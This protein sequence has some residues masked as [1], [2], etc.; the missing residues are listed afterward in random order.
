M[1][2]FLTAAASMI[3]GNVIVDSV[4]RIVIAYGI[5]RLIN[6]N[7]AKDNTPGARFRDE[8]VRLQIAP[9]TTNHIPILFGSAFYGG[10]ITDAQLTNANKTMWYCITL[11]DVFGLK[12]DD[13]AITTR[14]TNVYWNNQRVVFKADG[15]TIDYVV[16]DDGVVDASARDLVKIYLYR[17]GSATPTVITDPETNNPVYGS[18]SGV[19]ARTL[20]PGWTNDH[21]MSNLTFALVKLDYNRDKGITGLPD[22]KFNV[23]NDNYLPGNAIYSYLLNNRVGCDLPTS[24]IDITNLNAL[25]DYADDEISYLDADGT[26]KT[27]GDR[28]QINGL[29]DTSN[30]VL[31]NLEKLCLSSGCYL[32]YDI[33]AGKWGVVINRDAE[34]SLDFDDSNIISGITVTGTALDGIYNGV[35]IEFPHRELRDQSDFI[36]ID[37]PSEYRNANEPDNTLKTKFE[38]LNEPLQARSL[39]YLELYQNRMDQ[40]VTFTTDYS[41][42]NTEAGDII[43]VTNSVYDWDHKEFRVIRVKEVESDEGGIAVEITAQEYDATMYQAGGQPRRPGVPSEPIGIPTL[44]AIGTPSAPTIFQTNNQNAQPNI[45]LRS[46]VPGSTQ[47]GTSVIVDRMEFWYAEGTQAQNIPT[48][49]YKLLEVSVN[50]NGNP[51]TTG[52]NQDSQPIITLDAGNYLFRVRA[53]NATGYSDYSAATALAW[54][55]KQRTDE[56]DENTN[57]TPDTPSLSDLL[58]PLAMGAIAY[59]AYQALKPEILAALSNTDLGKLLGITNPAEIAD[60]K[61]KMEQQAA[62]FRII[63]AGNASLSAIGDSTVTFIAGEGIEITAVDVGHEITISATGALGGYSFTNIAVSGQP[64]VVAD[65]VGDTVTLVAGTGISIIT[66][67]N[68]DT[69]TISTSDGGGGGGEDISAQE[70]GSY[71][72]QGSVFPTVY[73]TNAINSKNAIFTHANLI[74]STTSANGVFKN[75]VKSTSI[76]KPSAGYTTGGN[77]P[78]EYF[79]YATAPY[80][81]NLSLVDQAWSDWQKWLPDTYETFQQQN[82]STNPL[83]TTALP[84][85]TVDGEYNCGGLTLR[86]PNVASLESYNWFMADTPK[87]STFQRRVI[88]QKVKPQPGKL[89]IFGISIVDLGASVPY[90]TNTIFAEASTDTVKGNASGTPIYP[91]N[92]AY[93]NSKYVVSSGEDQLYYATTFGSWNKVINVTFEDPSVPAQGLPSSPDKNKIILAPYSAHHQKFIGLCN[94]VVRNR[95]EVVSS[96][97][98][99]NWTEHN[100]IVSAQP[101]RIQVNPQ[102]HYL[103]DNALAW[104]S[105]GSTADK[106]IPMYS[107]NGLDWVQTHSNI[108]NDIN[109]NTRWCPTNN[110]WISGRKYFDAVN[111]SSISTV[112]Y[113]AG[114]PTPSEI[115]QNF[116]NANSATF[117][118]TA[119]Q[120]SAGQIPNVL[121]NNGID[122]TLNDAWTYIGN[123]QWMFI[124]SGGWTTTAAGPLTSKMQILDPFVIVYTG[125]L[126]GGFTSYKT[127]TIK[128]YDG[129]VSNWNANNGWGQQDFWVSRINSSVSEP[130]HYYV[131]ANN[132]AYFRDGFYVSAINEPTYDNHWYKITI[133]ASAIT[134]SKLY[135]FGPYSS[136]TYDFYEIG[137]WQILA[138]APSAFP[139]NIYAIRENNDAFALGSAQ[140]AGWTNVPYAYKTN[141]YFPGAS[142]NP[143]IKRDVQP[144]GYYNPTG[145]SISC[146]EYCLHWIT[147]D[148]YTTV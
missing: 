33:A 72:L 96:T 83:P 87:Y 71:C 61:Q 99:V 21:K 12:T 119:Y 105:E 18:F 23:R 90:A 69:I 123:N 101:E 147:E 81:P 141:Y 35:E 108:R 95:C 17:N 63:N 58:G 67:A 103:T 140:F 80:N 139:A 41:K 50:A 76:I 109:R 124:W 3:G 148:L 115:A 78:I 65:Q 28:Y 131:D 118:Y 52:S 37:L 31:A 16:N 127:S 49:S 77:E 54:D 104:T 43:T 88:N 133:G 60:I 48:S 40:V 27:L 36:R 121:T 97:D 111:S 136:N 66:N 8:G 19:D 74:V 144:F 82:G 53:G 57:F 135:E 13:S 128:K 142:N 130:L 7:V 94:H 6:R 143:Q 132:N 11:S 93:G 68:T 102:G 10:I 25:N 129:W 47:P 26:I 126:A 5:S 134:T 45:I 9:N 84:E 89:V 1:A 55:P 106:I 14:F 92:G 22:V 98:G 70:T 32:N 116:I 110:K 122:D 146:V 73:K 34:P 56:V 85:Y 107:L 100:K 86:T 64:T 117:S 114:V 137:N 29:L 112:G 24:A 91:K 145:S 2:G 42:I 138:A 15:V 44:G 125:T 30:N 38:M 113:A 20:M 39:A 46:V 51:F 75:V 62:G 59:F 79:Y 120:G 4:V